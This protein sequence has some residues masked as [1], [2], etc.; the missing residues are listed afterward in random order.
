MNDKPDNPYDMNSASFDADKYL[1]KL[2]KV[3]LKVL[4]Q[5]QKIMK[6]VCV[7][8]LQFE[9]NYGHRSSYCER[10]ADTS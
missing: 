8:E 2:L 9:T 7:A 10:H 1:Q 4:E 5:R 6:T 3:S